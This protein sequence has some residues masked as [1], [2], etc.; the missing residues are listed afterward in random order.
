[1]TDA[2]HSDI[3]EMSFE[4]ALK[5]LEEIVRKLE[6]GQGELEASITDYT[7]LNCH[8]EPRLAINISEKQW[9]R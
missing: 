9:H 6:A 2:T 4:A 5:E 1:M 3:A 7:R 8:S